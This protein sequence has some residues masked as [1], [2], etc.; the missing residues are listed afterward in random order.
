MEPLGPDDE[1]HTGMWPA[2]ALSLAF[3]A[4]AILYVF[5]R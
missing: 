2:V 4:A 5:C 3:W 1:E